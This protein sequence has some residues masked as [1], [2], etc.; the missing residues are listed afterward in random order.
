[1]NP[2]VEKLLLG[3]ESSIHATLL[4]RKN[5]EQNYSVAQIKARIS[6]VLQQ[7]EF[8][9]VKVVVAGKCIAVASIVENDTNVYRVRIRM[10]DATICEDQI[11]KCIES[12]VRKP[13][14]VTPPIAVQ[15]VVFG[16]VDGWF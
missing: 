15:Y 7:K 2:S 16:G 8:E 11:Y 1:M 3:D 9:W 12:Y 10:L 6:S 13:H 14:Q 5:I 4:L